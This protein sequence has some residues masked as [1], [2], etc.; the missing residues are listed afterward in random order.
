MRMLFSLTVAFWGIIFSFLSLCFGQEQETYQCSYRAGMS[1]V[2]DGRIDQE[3]F[4]NSL[5]ASSD[6]MVYKKNITASPETYFKAAYNDEA[7]FIGVCCKEPNIK[8]IKANFKDNESVCKDDGIELFIFPQ[9][10]ETY[11]HFIVNT[12]GFRYNG[13]GYNQESLY[14]WSAFTYKGEDFYSIE[15]KLPFELFCVIPAKNEKWRVNIARN[16]NNAK[17]NAS[18]THTVWGGGG[19]HNCN[20]FNLFLFPETLSEKA[21]KKIKSELKRKI[22]TELSKVS[23]YKSNC[24]Q[25]KKNTAYFL[26]LDKDCESIRQDLVDLDQLSLT[27]MYSLLRQSTK[28]TYNTQQLRLMNDEIRG[29]SVLKSFFKQE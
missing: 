5:P 19:F 15:I 3:L 6:F 23:E 16:I 7:L 22:V 4:W 18:T 17:L 29:N 21:T 1:P 14:N 26:L 20:Q 13:K 8:E 25:Y 24:I 27:E 12:E 9:G 2:F 28:L 11:W 10:M